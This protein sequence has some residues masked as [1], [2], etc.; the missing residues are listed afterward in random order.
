MLPIS[1]G[2]VDALPCPAL[3]RPA[4]ALPRAALPCPAVVVVVVGDAAATGSARSDGEESEC[5]AE[6][7]E[8]EVGELVLEPLR[9]LRENQPRGSQRTPPCQQVP[10]MSPR[11]YAYAPLEH[12][13]LVGSAL[14]AL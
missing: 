4:L 6:R 12:S 5:S 10:T 2:E 1:P 14:S 3:P 7:L 11:P 8:P 13:I 9:H